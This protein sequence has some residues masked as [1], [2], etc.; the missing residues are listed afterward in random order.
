MESP[1]A[2]GQRFLGTGEFLWLREMA[3]PLR[4][5]LGDRAARVST[6][7]AP[8][9]LVRLAA[10]RDAGRREIAPALGRRNRHSTAKARDLLGWQPRPAAHTVVD[11]ARSL[12]DHGA[13]S[14]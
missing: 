9:L 11:C 6:R 3:K 12:L 4:V 5:E 1:A 8:D 10:R 7:R 14:P 13:V 2:A